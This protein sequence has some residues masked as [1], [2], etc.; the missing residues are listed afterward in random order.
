MAME[1]A[2]CLGIDEASDDLEIPLEHPRRAP[3]S[4]LSRA[5]V[6]AVT[7]G[8]ASAC[9]YSLSS[10]PPALSKA[11]HF[12][13]KWEPWYHVTQLD[14][15]DG[16]LNCQKCRDSFDTKSAAVAIYQMRV[17]K[18]TP[19]TAMSVVRAAAASGCDK[20]L[21][22]CTPATDPLMLC[23]PDLEKLDEDHGTCLFRVECEK[24][25]SVEEEQEKKPEVV[26]CELC[27]S[28]YGKEQ[29]C[30][31]IYDLVSGTTPSQTAEKEIR[32]ATW[33]SAQCDPI[34]SSQCKPAFDIGE[35]CADNLMKLDSE[36]KTCYF[37]H[38][39]KR[40]PP[41]P[42]T[43][44]PLDCKA[45]QKLYDKN[46]ACQAVYNA[47]A[48]KIQVGVKEKL[49][50]GAIGQVEACTPILVSQ[51]GMDVNN[52]IKYCQDTLHQLDTEQN[53]CFFGGD[54][55]Q[56]EVAKPE[57]ISGGTCKAQK[58]CDECL[59]S[60]QCE[61]HGTLGLNPDPI[62]CC[63]RMKKCIDHRTFEDTSCEGK[64][65]C[66]P[67]ARPEANRWGCSERSAGYPATCG[68]NCADDWD[69][70][71]WVQC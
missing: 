54:C 29:G 12:P 4:S 44:P 66:G 31:A 22:H 27:K 46:S 30:K 13:L 65:V 42:L 58:T 28:M 50:W 68:T 26:D 56:E 52:P 69:Y 21:D 23:M 34:F 14:E 5:I 16:D 64:S 8:V 71:T 19:D 25:T 39:C 48:G 41:P 62:Y 57:D 3:M 2:L 24:E 17:G 37:G 63:P 49:L 9:I 7:L 11:T 15:E 20:V 45:C 43:P 51:C 59:H 55:E 18:I 47:A 32:G 40:Q 33:N 1:S 10:A 36:H 35:F 61:G 60:W 6:G 53:T 70:K 38:G 67:Q